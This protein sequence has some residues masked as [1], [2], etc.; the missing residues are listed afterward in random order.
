[1]GKVI[2]Q[3]TSIF[4]VCFFGQN[5]LYSAK[6]PQFEH[7]TQA[8][9][10]STN[11]EHERVVR[12]CRQRW[13]QPTR[14]SSALQF[15]N[16]IP[17]RSKTFSIENKKK[18]KVLATL[19]VVNHSLALNPHQANTFRILFFSPEKPSNKKTRRITNE[20]YQKKTFAGQTSDGWQLDIDFPRG[21]GHDTPK[22]WQ[23]RMTPNLDLL[24]GVVSIT[25]RCLCV[26]AWVRPSRS[27]YSW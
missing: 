18:V 3:Q 7:E 12:T 17:W 22:R 11:T 9:E 4:K 16:P 19:T 15:Q 5:T 13:R 10:R 2:V 26:H 8:Q 23:P 6:Y 24:P 14:E 1:M 27:I 20:R 25:Y 21:S